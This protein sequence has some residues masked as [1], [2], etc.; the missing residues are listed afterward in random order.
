M[1]LFANVESKSND[2]PGLFCNAFPNNF[3]KLEHIFAIS[4]LN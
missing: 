2:T 1:K 4:N 3:Q